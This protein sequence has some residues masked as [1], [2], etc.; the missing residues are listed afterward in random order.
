MLFGKKDRLIGLDIGSRSI[1]AAEISDTK[2]GKTLERFG[3]IDISPGLIEDG[4]INNAEQV[5][6]TIRQLFKNYGIKGS[7]VAL[8]VGGYSVI[9]KK[10]NV[11]SMSEDQLQDTI[12]FEAEQYIPFDIADVN[13]DF[14]I[15]GDD[16]LRKECLSIQIAA[17]QE[18]IHE[19]P[20]KFLSH[21]YLA[22]LYHADR[23]L[24]QAVVHYR[25]ALRIKPDS[26]RVLYNLGITLLKQEAFAEATASFSNAL[27]IEPDFYEARRRLGFSLAAQGLIDQAV[28]EYLIAVR[29][30]PDDDKLH[31]D[32]GILLFQSGET[33]RAIQHFEAAL[34][35]NPNL[36]EARMNLEKARAATLK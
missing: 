11:Q 19:M 25:S 27:R 24:D 3:I 5:A 10:I 33:A 1:K 13:L 8:S 36:G 30:S 15:L 18:K 20:N 21:H 23:Q 26:P 4:A 7:N 16:E 34:R 6:D 12:S 29:N 32:L 17:I 35:L 2:K 28:R 31:N 14:Q 22:N 9:V